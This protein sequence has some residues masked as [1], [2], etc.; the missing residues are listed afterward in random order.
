MSKM[1]SAKA[2]FSAEGMVAMTRP[3]SAMISAILRRLPLASTVEIPT[4]FSLS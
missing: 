2:S 4:A 3:I 1:S